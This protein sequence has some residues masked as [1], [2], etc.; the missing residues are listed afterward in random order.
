MQTSG[1]AVVL[2]GQ[3]TQSPTFTAPGTEG[4]LSFRLTVTDN[5]GALASDDVVITVSKTG[6]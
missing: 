3:N 4:P 2:S 6:R 1:T 5:N